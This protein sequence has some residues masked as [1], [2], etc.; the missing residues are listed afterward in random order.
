M[1]RPSTNPVNKYYSVDRINRKSEC[2][3]VGCKSVLKSIASSNLENHLKAMHTTIYNELI[4]TKKKLIINDDIHAPKHKKLNAGTQLTL[5]QV[6][7]YEDKQI[8]LNMTQDELEE[9]CVQLVTENGL[10]YNFVDYKGF[11]RIIDPIIYA[12][13]TKF[14]INPS[15]LKDKVVKLS[16]NIRKIITDELKGRLLSIKIDTATRFGRSI[17][18]YLFY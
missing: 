7:F 16:N 3:I 15:N 4:E 1:G 17:I 5:S 18:G 12:I 14:T 11:R 6:S 2:K 13:G 8:K 9:S 10:P